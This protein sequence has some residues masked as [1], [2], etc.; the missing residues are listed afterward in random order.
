MN[1]LKFV[2]VR[3]LLTFGVFFLS[4]SN[5]V[6]ADG[7]QVT[8]YPFRAEV[9]P[10]AAARAG[11]V[12]APAPCRSS[13]ALDRAIVLG[14]FGPAE[15][16][17]LEFRTL[18]WAVQEAVS[19]AKSTASEG[20]PAVE[21]VNLVSKSPWSDGATAA[22]RLIFEGRVVGIVGGVDGE[23]T[24]L[25]ETIVAKA[26]V[27]LLSPVATDKTVN[28][29]NV[30][31]MFSLLPGDHLI[32]PALAKWLSRESPDRVAVI[33]GNDHDSQWFWRELSKWLYASGIH[34]DPVVIAKEGEGQISELVAHVL[35]VDP[36]WVILSG[37]RNLSVPCV[38]ELR[39]KAPSVRIMCDARAARVAFLAELQTLAD[40]IICPYLLSGGNQNKQ[41]LISR[42]HAVFNLE[43]DYAVL[44]TYDAVR[45]LLEAAAQ[46][47]RSDQEAIDRAE[48]LNRLR[49]LSPYHGVSGVITWDR[50][51]ANQRPVQIGIIRNAKLL[52]E[53]NTIRELGAP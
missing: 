52:V 48:L 2:V 53:D 6:L 37:P 12:T 33:I 9:R 41:E 49:L 38:R 42:F 40:G 51:G 18:W 13:L 10:F 36:E 16:T 32:A 30:P 35:Q 1:I 19:D 14:Y 7:D 26:H 43:P 28:L 34:P 50:L 17:D 21:V 15:T 22:A 5:I 45:I 20:L 23:A 47:A 3:V 4:L 25:A 44:A 8:V 29:A 27:P 31:W 46:C 39:R 24:H 11:V